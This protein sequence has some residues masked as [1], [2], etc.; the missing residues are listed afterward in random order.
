[1]KKRRV[2]LF[3]HCFVTN[4]GGELADVVTRAKVKKFRLLECTINEIQTRFV[5]TTVS[6]YD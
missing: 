2:A 3:L 6:T 4:A 1:M 5:R